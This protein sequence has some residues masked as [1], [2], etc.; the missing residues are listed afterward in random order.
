MN[1]TS[2]P[3][4]AF[5]DGT[6]QP[7]LGL[8]TWKYGENASQRAAEVAAL[9]AAL[10]IGY[11]L[12]DTAE[13]YG[14]GGAET[15]LGEALRGALREGVVKRDEVFI[16]SKVYP[17][18]AGSAAMRKSCEASLARLQLDCI[19]LYLLHWRG[20]VPLADT[21]AGFEALLAA[22]RVAR[23]GVSNFDNGDLIELAGLRGG[24]GCAA[25]Q[26]YY[27]L[28]ERGP[29]FELLPWQRE[30]AMPLMAYSPIDQGKL[31]SGHATLA[32]VAERHRATS[33]QVALAALI[34]KPGVMV[35]PKSRD[36]A[37]LRENWAAQVLRLSAEDHAELDRAFPPP[38]RK[39]PLAM[40]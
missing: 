32:R 31:A 39:R 35:I 34:A 28:G 11:R 33:A 9:R 12:F 13:M 38:K 19:D 26:V 25:N 15:V 14:D 40:T 29:E 16:V 30:R 5:A 2:S 6:R 22:G 20:S 21:V 8:G 7:A 17:H 37:R 36:A 4:V 1:V 10:E 23:W 27:S 3:T 18:N 24:G